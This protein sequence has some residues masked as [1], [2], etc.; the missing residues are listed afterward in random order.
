MGNYFNELRWKII[1]AN[2]LLQFIHQVTISE[3]RVRL[4]E[5]FQYMYLFCWQFQG[6]ADFVDHFLNLYFMFLCCLHLEIYML[7]TWPIPCTVVVCAGEGAQSRRCSS[8]I[9][10]MWDCRSWNIRSHS[11]RIAMMRLR[12]YLCAP[13]RIKSLLIVTDAKSIVCASKRILANY[14]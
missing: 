12:S 5:A 2:N 13:N 10:R 11:R 8:S 7:K 4:V 3:L 9:E 1:W 6:G 14:S